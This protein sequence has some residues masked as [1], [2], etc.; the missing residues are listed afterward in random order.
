MPSGASWRAEP[1]DVETVHA[2]G[3]RG[4]VEA[5]IIRARAILA[6]ELRVFTRVF[7]L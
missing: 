5:Y 4:S 6:L 1:D 2:S 3:V 7:I